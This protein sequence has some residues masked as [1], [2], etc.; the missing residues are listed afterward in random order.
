LYILKN[1]LVL[2]GA[3]KR[4]F[5]LASFSPPENSVVL[6]LRCDIDLDE[7]SQFGIEVK[8]EDFLGGINHEK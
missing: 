2:G 8:C 7:K 4:F 3:V 6:H 5:F 1:I